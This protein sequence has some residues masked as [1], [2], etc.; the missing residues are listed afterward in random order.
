[1]TDNEDDLELIYGSGNIWRDFGYPDADIRQA[2]D[3]IAARIIGV[4]DDRGLSTRAAS[5]QTGFAAAD[6]SRVRNAKYGRFTLDRMMRMLCALDPGAEITVEVTDGA[7][8]RAE[9]DEPQPG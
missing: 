7:S 5:E 8:A 2:K 3:I 4:L 1:M 6:F 9:P